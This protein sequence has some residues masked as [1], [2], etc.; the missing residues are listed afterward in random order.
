MFTRFVCSINEILVTSQAGVFTMSVTPRV[1][2]LGCDSDGQQIG[3]G[4]V[5]FLSVIE[6]D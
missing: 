2:T 3:I 6:C 4:T 1:F 5:L